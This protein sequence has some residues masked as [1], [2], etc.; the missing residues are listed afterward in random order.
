MKWNKKKK[1]YIYIYIVHVPPGSSN[2]HLGLSMMA[3][4]IHLKYK[5]YIYNI[6][7]QTIC[8]INDEKNIILCRK[9]MNAFWSNRRVCFFKKFKN[10]IITKNGCSNSLKFSSCLNAQGDQSS[11]K[12][13]KTKIARNQQHVVSKKNSILVLVKLINPFFLTGIL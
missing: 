4:I 5:I 2:C 10:I 7:Q 6:K 3:Y 11:N 12:V 1:I 13:F 8:Y 9:N